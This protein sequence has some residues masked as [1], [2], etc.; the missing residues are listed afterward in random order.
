[1]VMDSEPLARHIT[2]IVGLRAESMPPD[3]YGYWP[4]AGMAHFVTAKGNTVPQFHSTGPARSTS[5]TRPT[6]RG[7]PCAV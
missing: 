1:M 4:G 3:T 2:T 6:T 5:L 7:T